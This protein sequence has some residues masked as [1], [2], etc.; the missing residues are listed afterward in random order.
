MQPGTWA[1]LQ[2][3]NLNA[4]FSSSDM[5]GGASGVI[6]GYTDDAVWDPVSRQIFFLGGDH[7]WSV[8]TT[9]KFVSYSEATNSWQKRATQP[10][11]ASGVVHGYHHS[12]LD[13]AAG[14]FYHRPFSEQAVHRYNIASQTWDQ[15]PMP[16][17]PFTGDYN[18][19]CDALEYFPELGGL[20]WVSG[21]GSVYLYRPSTNQW[22]TIAS[23]LAIGGTWH[24]AEYNPVHQVLVFYSEQTGALY[25]LSSSGQVTRLGDPPI[26]LYKGGYVGP[27]TVD[28]VSGKYLAL[29]PSTGQL[30]TYDVLTDVWQLQS[31]PTKPNFDPFVVAS[32]IST[33]GVN[34]FVSCANGATCH[35]YLYKHSG[36]SPPPP[37]PPPPDTTSPTVSISS[38]AAGSTVSGTTT[39]SANASDNV[40]VAGVQ[41]KLDGANLGA[42]NTTSP[43]SASWNTTTA[44]NGSHTLTAVARDAAGNQTTSASVT[45]T[46]SNSAP[47]SSSFAQKCAQTG[48]LNCFGF[49]ST[50]SLFYT[51]PTGTQC[52]AVFAGQTNYGFGL[53]RS[54]PGNTAAVLQNGQCVYPQIDT[55][56]PHSGGGALKFTIPSN[57]GADSGGFFA[58]PFKRYADGTFPYI[59]PGSPLGNVV[60]FQFYQKFDPNFAG[61]DFQCTGGGCTGWKQAIW[62]GNPPNGSSSS[63]IEATMFNGWQRG[64][65]QMY[66]QQGSDEYGIEDIT[67]CTY[68][69]ATSQGGSGSGFDS[70]P[71]YSAPL[72]PNCAHYPANQWIEFTGRL[73]IRGT[74]NAPS[75]RVQLW[76]NGQLVIDYGAARV[77]WSGG[78][79]NGFGQFL[80]SPYHTRKDPT[81]AHPVGYTWYDDVIVSTQPIAMGGSTLTPPT[82]DTT[83]P[84]ITSITASS[85]TSSGV[86]VTWTSDEAADSQV[87][88]GVST[89]YGN[90]SSLDSSLVTSHSQTISGLSAGTTYNYRVKSR[91]AAGNLATSP[92]VTFTTPSAGSGGGSPPPVTGLIGY[93]KLDEATGNTASDSSGANNHGSLSNGPIWTA[94]RVGGALQFNA[95]DNGNDTDDPRLVIGRNFDIAAVPFTLSAWVN[96]V[97]FADYRAILSKRDSYAAADMRLDWGLKKSSGTVYL[98]RSGV[99]VDFAYAPQV[100]T[101]THLTVVATSTDTRLYVNG[102]LQQTAGVF[103]VGTDGTANTV[104]GGTGEP[105]GGDN[106]PFKGKIDEVRTYNRA[107]SA[108]EI[109]DLFNFAGNT[110]PTSFSIPQNGG[111]AWLTTTTTE[112]IQVGYARVQPDT[113]ASRPSGVAIFGLR[114]GGVLVTEAGVPASAAI[115][116]GRIYAEVNGPVNT[117]IALANPNNQDAVISFYFTDTAGNDF[118][119]GSFTLSANHQM[120]AF[121]NQTPFNGLASMQGT[122]TF[123]SSVPVGVIAV[124]GFTNERNEFLIT[125]LPVA[126]IPD[127]STNATLLPHFAAGGG[128]TTQV[129][130][131][132]PSDNALTGTV[133]FLGSGSLTQAAAV[134]SMSVNGVTNSSFSYMI[135][136]RAA[137]RLVTGNSGGTL[138]VGSVRVSPSGAVAPV[139]LAVFSYK[140][141][142]ITVSE[143]GVS[144]LPTGTAFRMYAEASGA[145]SQI[146]SI[147]TGVAVA[148]PSP[149][150]V[151]VS[152]ELTRLDGSSLGLPVTVTVPA[153]GQ[154]AQFIKE[155]F[156][157]LPTTFQGFLKATATG[158]IGVTG[159]RSRYNERNDFLITTTPPRNEE[160]VSAGTEVVFPHIVRGGGYSTQII[161]FGQ[162]GSG[163]LWLNSQDGTPWSNENLQR[164]Q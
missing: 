55:T 32:S 82:V 41:F 109:Q 45:V 42:E 142:G 132:N 118:G 134:L 138:Q 7:N 164:I 65:P 150:P 62:Y 101:W 108:S 105:A 9:A 90:Q 117:G 1:E 148:N 126:T 74:S 144:A 145:L 52:D 3:N 129:I 29:T 51:W 49:D 24:S 12:A 152:L 151:A 80:L 37:P 64:V 61:I 69:K 46:V 50:S 33:Y 115:Q 96:P 36:G 104:I 40:G 34:L 44:G 13:S 60:Y 56:S 54:G 88:Y 94:G 8:P 79:G 10:S 95:T 112:S 143:A 131:T 123:S 159:I 43:Y 85:I 86:T 92:N 116:S 25:K 103:S 141:N 27:L 110:Q 77:D 153:D 2:T 99:Q 66:G 111:Q 68:A 89:S 76:V 47:T 23:T 35:V 22:S 58:E 19:C 158:P 18:N 28:P 59:G 67:G 127:T 136:P 91:D 48:V 121:L 154:I 72:N 114:T 106:D 26:A 11:W 75:S 84:S 63:L 130:L 119:Q 6:I 70:R 155:L 20:V 16:N 162:S 140:N 81:R 17:F 161:I 147:Q 71:N 157:A 133:Q 5:G 124:R 120:S 93:W 57:S 149:A 39:V 113:G 100:N 73:E 156:P 128:W 30:Y 4:T 14:T 107:L 78:D 125:T 160:L 139:A 83:A 146:G 53:D 31:S 102:A 97:D 87:D 38:P 122:F 137:V 135:P 15:P 163:R 21:S 98:G